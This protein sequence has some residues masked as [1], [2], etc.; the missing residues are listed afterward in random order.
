MEYKENVLDRIEQS[1]VFM[2]DNFKVLFFPLVI[3]YVWVYFLFTYTWVYFMD[4]FDVNN[5]YS[6]WN[7]YLFSWAILFG[8]IYLTFEIWVLLWL[9][10]TICDIDDWN[11]FDVVSNYKYWFLNIFESFKTYYYMFMYVYLI[12]SIIFIGWWIYFINIAWLWLEWVKD[13]FSKNMWVLILG[14]VLIT[15]FFIFF[16]TYRSNKT[17]F[18]I[19]S[20]VSKNT[21]DKENFEFSVSITKGNWWRVFWNFF[22]VWIII[23]LL[24]SIIS[25]AFETH[26]LVDTIAKNSNNLDIDK[27][28]KEFRVNRIFSQSIF[29][30]I[31]TRFI[32]VLSLL[33]ISIFTYIF[34]KRLESETLS[35]ETI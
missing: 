17:V 35:K 26:T 9:F 18:S 7:M 20:A 1:F 34:F 6:V 23:W 4:S 3:F 32:T 33:F 30:D 28:I 10:K 31:I 25:S 11:E 19:V 21:F 13:F 16:I 29:Q 27:M 15:F 8:L 2:K 24:T 14:A 5:L 12:P 22:L